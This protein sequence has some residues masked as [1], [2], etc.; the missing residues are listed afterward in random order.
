MI[1]HS[2]KLRAMKHISIMMASL[3][4]LLLLTTACND[5]WKDEQYSHY[6]SFKAPLNDGGVSAIYVPYTRHTTNAAGEQVPM[7]G[8]E[9]K[10][11]YQLPIIVSGSTDNPSDITVNIS[12]SD[13]LAILN[14][15]QYQNR[16]DLYYHELPEQYVSFN[17]THTIK[18]G[19]NVSLYQLDFN[20]QG[21]DMSERWVLP[22]EISEGNGYTAHPRKHYAKALLR[23]YPFND[24]S[25]SYSATTQKMADINDPN[26]ATGGENS[27]AYV[28]DENTVFFYAG[29]DIDEKRTDRHLYKIYAKFTP[30]VENPMQGT[31]DFYEPTGNADFGFTN[32]AQAV[33]AVTERMDEVLPYLMYRDII[34]SGIDYQFND[35][36]LVPG[37]PR[38]YIVQGS[39]T[40]ERKINTQMSDEDMAIEW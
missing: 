31:V 36:T 21:I 16:T 14:Y 5:E 13:T 29:N 30:S 25:G 38:Q 23:V 40:M 6:L 20:F 9:G 24:Y 22:L 39:M 3:A 34:I 28:V 17:P 12:R 1:N 32:N 26:N 35:Y 27:R 37:E 15:A 19:E 8:A 11:T 4:G 33:Y 18:K 2:K 10:S 7:Y